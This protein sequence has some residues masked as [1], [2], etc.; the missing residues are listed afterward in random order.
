MPHARKIAGSAAISG[1]VDAYW[2]RHTVNSTPFTSAAESE[3]YLEWR[4]DQYPLFR[5]F[6]DLWGKHDDEVL[7]DYGCGPGNDLAGFLLY[8]TAAKVIGIDISAKALALA[9]DRLA[10]HGV[11]PRRFELVQV[12]DQHP[13]IPLPDESIDY[14][15]CEGVLHHTSHPL[16]ILKEFWRTL[17]A[18]GKA[19]VMVYNRDSLWFHLYTAYDSMIRRGQ[20]PGLTVEEAFAK[21]TDGERCPIARCYKEQEW[22]ALCHE[23]GLKGEFVGGYLSLHEL[24][25]LQQLGT[26]AVNDKR[27]GDE[28][29]EFLR[30]LTYD[31]KGLPMYH[32]RHAG[33]GG[34]YNLH[35]PAIQSNAP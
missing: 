4:F 21:N 9:R 29:R 14:I 12:S 24:S 35:K 6:M 27:L 22:L 3:H 2:N 26:E 31:S 34:V 17:K 8:T 33:I 15:Y 19:C 23:A 10:L 18:G 28:H 25:L 32:G 7:L 13:T 20:F 11:L 5:E 16:A 1:R 30:S